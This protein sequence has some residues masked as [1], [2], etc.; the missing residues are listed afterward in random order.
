MVMDH[1]GGSRFGWNAEITK[2]VVQKI[3]RAVLV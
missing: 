3:M 2:G 1:M